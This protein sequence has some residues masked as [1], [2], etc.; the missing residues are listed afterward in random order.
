[1]NGY[2]KMGAGMFIFCV[3][4][5]LLLQDWA[6]DNKSIIPWLLY[7]LSGMI[8]FFDGWRQHRNN[9]E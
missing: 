7:M 1:M 4:G 2:L 5:Y 6:V 3:G 8:F 9:K